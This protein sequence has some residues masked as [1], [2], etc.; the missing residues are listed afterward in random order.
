MQSNK[1][2]DFLNPTKPRQQMTPACAFLSSVVSFLLCRTSEH[3]TFF[4]RSDAV[5]KAT[6][7]CKGIFPKNISA[8][9][10]A[11]ACVMVTSNVVYLWVPPTY[12]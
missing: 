1:V 12:S 5:T 11:F 4:I 7:T 3:T 2:A 8:R 6:E 9:S 10:P